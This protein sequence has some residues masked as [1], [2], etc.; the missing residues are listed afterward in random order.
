MQAVGQLDDEDTRV[1]RGGEKHF[2]EAVGDGSLRRGFFQAVEFAD[3]I[4]E[5]G[6]FFAKLRRHVGFLED[7]VFED[8]VQQSRLQHR[9]VKALAGED[10][11][12]GD[13]VDEVG[14][15]AL[16]FLPLMGCG[17]IDSTAQHFFHV[18]GV[19]VFFQFGGEVVIRRLQGLGAAE[20]GERLVF[21]GKRRRVH[22]YSVVVSSGWSSASSMSS[23]SSSSASRSMSFS[24]SPSPSGISSATGGTGT[25]L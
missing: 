1:V 24:A 22:G 10:A 11:A 3:A 12:D 20:Y 4:N 16:A 21:E 9:Q 13:G 7:G 25:G 6:D 5:A 19:E 14:F 8:V 2:A 17:A 15:A 23:L 18:F